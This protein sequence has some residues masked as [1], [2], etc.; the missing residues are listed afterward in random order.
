MCLSWWPFEYWDELDYVLNKGAEVQQ[1]FSVD[2]AVK[3]EGKV[4]S[5]YS[6]CSTEQQIDLRL[7]EHIR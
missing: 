1:G 2:E 3:V 4:I 7:L 5:C 6:V